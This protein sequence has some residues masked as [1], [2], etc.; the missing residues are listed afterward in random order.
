MS[1]LLDKLYAFSVQLYPTGRAFRVFPGSVKSNLIKGLNQSS[2]RFFEDAT[3]ILNSIL[4]DN[5]FFTADDATRWEQRLGMI[6]NTDADLEDRKAAIIRKI[7]HPG[8]ILARQS[9]GYLQ[10][11]LQLAGFNVYVH[12][13]IPAQ[14]PESVLFVPDI[15]EMG[16]PEMGEIE[17]GSALSYYADLFLFPEM[18]ELEM[19]ELEMGEIQYKNQ[20]ANS[21]SEPVDQ[22]FQ[23]GQNYKCTFFIG[24]QIKGTFADVPQVRKDEF[25]QLILRIKPVQTV[26]YLLINYI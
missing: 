8:T 15:G 17:M 11:Q 2:A 19:G 5:E 3:G 1:S 12:E 18:G 24:G 6:V 14:T 23:T 10:D 13:N 7:N 16:E 4:P 9:A 20:I 21:I 25:R 26:G 22:A